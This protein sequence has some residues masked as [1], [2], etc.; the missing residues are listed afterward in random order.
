MALTSTRENRIL[1]AINCVIT[2]DRITETYIGPLR[3]VSDPEAIGI[4]KISDQ[5]LLRLWKQRCLKHGNLFVGQTLPIDDD[6]N[7]IY[8]VQFPIDEKLYEI[9][10]VLDYIRLIEFT[11]GDYNARA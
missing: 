10:T 2:N 3:S 8:S 7:P 5:N 11:N 6:Y 1:T 4:F 9:N